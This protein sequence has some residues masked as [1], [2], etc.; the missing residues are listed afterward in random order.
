[1]GAATINLN[2][3]NTSRINTSEEDD[4]SSS[5]EEATDM[6]KSKRKRLTTNFNHQASSNFNH[7]I[8]NHQAAEN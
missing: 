5:H 1:M 4:G 3:R 2:H 6:R 8:S 7:Q